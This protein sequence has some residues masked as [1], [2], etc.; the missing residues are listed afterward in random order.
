MNRRGFLKTTAA[1]ALVS[2]LPLPTV[3]RASALSNVCISI[4]P[5]PTVSDF[6]GLDWVEV[7]A[8]SPV[9]D[10]IHQARPSIGDA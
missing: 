1:T 9:P 3:S 10:L 7:G 8:V 6:A 2:L 4:A 5:A